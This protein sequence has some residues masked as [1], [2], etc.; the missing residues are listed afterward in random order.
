MPIVPT[1]NDDMGRY[2]RRR[3]YQRRERKPLIW[4]PCAIGTALNPD[5]SDNPQNLVKGVTYK[6]C[7]IPLSQNADQEVILERIRGNLFWQ[8]SSSSG[9][10]MS[11]TIFGIILP[12]IVVGNVPL[13]NPLPNF[14]HPYDAEGT[15]DFP[16]VI[17]ACAPTGT[18]ITSTSPLEVDVKAKRKMNKDDLFTIGLHV[19][20]IFT[21][22]A[23]TNI[24]GY[25]RGGLRALQKIL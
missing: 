7:D 6:V 5:G 22:G 3:S 25:L 12:D 10:T 20:D 4:T 18:T 15:D 13:G 19:L 16:M 24:K 17:D 9:A 14:P 8:T 21:S 2:R 11:A 23:G 1:A